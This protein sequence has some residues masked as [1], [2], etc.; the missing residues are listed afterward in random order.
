MKRKNKSLASREME[1][2]AVRKS[3]SLIAFDIML[4]LMERFE[5]DKVHPYERSPY[6]V[7]IR[8]FI[9]RRGMYMHR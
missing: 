9:Y 8:V 6:L 2:P 3:E 4:R 1:N 5:V 7:L